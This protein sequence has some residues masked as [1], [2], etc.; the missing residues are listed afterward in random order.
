MLKQAGLPTDSHT[1]DLTEQG[2]RKLFEQWQWW[3]QTLE[4]KQFCPHLTADGYSVIGVEKP[5]R[6][7][8][9]VL[10]LYY[11]TKLAAQTFHQLRHQLL[12]CVGA[13][14]K[15][16]RQK[17]Q[18]FQAK[19]SAV[20]QADGYREQADLLMA[21]L[22]E[23]KPGLS[24][25]TLPHFE[26]GK[27][28]KIS[29]DPERNAVQNAQFFYK[30]HQK[31]RRSQDFVEPLLQAVQVEM[32]YLEQVEDAIAI[33]QEYQEPIDLVTLQEIRDELVQQNYLTLPDYRR[34]SA[35]SK[36][37]YRTFTTPN[38]FTVLVGRNNKQNDHLTFRTAGPYDLWFHAQEISGSHVLLRL[39]AGAQIEDQDL[40]FCADVA[41]YFSRARHSDQVPVVYTQPKYVFKPKGAKP[42]MTVYTHETV[43]W[44][45]PNAVTLESSSDQ[46]NISPE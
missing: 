9:Q 1:T 18:Q 22:H 16:L 5:T 2:W 42:G 17:E 8:S 24:S 23:W 10:C 44:G 38:H 21:Y 3:L 15:K 27:P 7:L 45:D 35:E 43:L 4:S 19:L 29:L 14:L 13:K 30:R 39:D 46:E 37:S 31:L 11:E 26:T 28:V 6:T 36:F 33:V 12:Q 40:V 20:G 32:A 41:A 34:P 25:I